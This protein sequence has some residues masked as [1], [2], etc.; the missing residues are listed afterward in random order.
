M[1][2]AAE[3]ASS[4]GMDRPM[5]NYKDDIDSLKA[6]IIMLAESVAEL[7]TEIEKLKR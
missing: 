4:F 6:T 5:T 2:N 3:L 7:Q 1:K